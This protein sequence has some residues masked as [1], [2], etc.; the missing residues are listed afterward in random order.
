ML[1]AA[2]KH[3]GSKSTI[4]HGVIVAEKAEVRNSTALVAA[5]IKELKRG[6]E[7]D[8][9]ERRNVNQREFTRVRIPGDKP[10]EGWIETRFIISKGIVEECNKLAQEAKDVPSQALGKTKDKLKL[11]LKPGRNSE[12]VMMLPAGTKFDIIGRARAE[13]H[14]EGDD[15]KSTKVK[16]VKATGPEPP[17]FDNWYEV[18]MDDNSVVKAGWLYA[19]AVEITPPDA[20]SGLPG[21]GRRFA[22]WQPFGT[23]IDSQTQ[24]ER[25]NYIILDR[26]AYS[27]DDK[28]DFE[29]IYIVVWDNDKHEY[30]SIFIEQTRGVYPLKVEANDNGFLFSVPLLNKEEQPALARFQIKHDAKTNKYSVSRVVEPKPKPNKPAIKKPTGK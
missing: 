1:L 30:E 6:E 24:T 21:A 25:A 2:C 19:E 27:K 10:I 11:R 20:I 23:E 8:I 22:A 17:K 15:E 7:V 14:S 12:V 4:D 26:Y 3:G 29:R 28:S 16:P 18:R 9:L 5:P 13:R